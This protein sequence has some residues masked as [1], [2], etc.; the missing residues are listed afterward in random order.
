VLPMG[1]K[2]THPPSAKPGLK[3]KAKS[4]RPRKD[5]LHW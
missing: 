4:G 3:L 2:A 1:S 5:G